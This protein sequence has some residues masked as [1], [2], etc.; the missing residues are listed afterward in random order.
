MDRGLSVA[1]GL[2][3]SRA[4]PVVVVAAL[5][6]STVHTDIE[7][8]PPLYFVA[9]WL[10]TRIDLTPELLRASSLFA[11]RRRSRSPTRSACAGPCPLAIAGSRHERIRASSGRP[12]WSTLS[13]LRRENDIVGAEA[14]QQRDALDRALGRGGEP[15]R[16]L[17]SEVGHHSELG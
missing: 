14:P 13:A 1:E 17:R 6:I 9:A 15:Q 8:T 16:A 3:G 12:R 4:L 7:I 10:A 11:G 5:T 2:A